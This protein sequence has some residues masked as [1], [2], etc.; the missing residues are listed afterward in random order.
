ME[1]TIPR[2]IFDFLKDYPPFSLLP[3]DALEAVAAEVKVRYFQ[4]GQLV[5]N[6]GDT[7]GAHVFIVREGAIQLYREAE[8]EQ[9]LVEQCDEGDVFGIRPLLAEEDYAL[10]AKAAE[11]SLLYAVPVAG[12]RE[13]LEQNPKI[14]LYLATTFAADVGERYHK[15]FKPSLFHDKQGPEY[16]PSPLIEVQSLTGSKTPV[17][18]LPDTTIQQAAA[19]M[20]EREVGSIIITDADDRPVGIITD[21]DLRK[22]VA[23]GQVGLREK[24]ASI[25][26]SPVIT[27]PPNLQMAEVQIEMV[28]NRINHLCV[29]EDGS[30]DSKVIGVLSEHDLMVMQGNN[31][32]ILIREIRRCTEAEALRSIRERAEVLLEGYIYQEVAISFISAIMT[33]LNDEIIHRAIELSEQEM[34]DEGY[35]APQAG[36]CWMALGSEGRGEQLLRTDQDNALVFEDVPEEE[37]EATKAYYLELAGRVTHKLNQVGFE[38][39]PADMMASNPDWCLSLEQWKLQFSRWIKEPEPKAVMYCT[40]F[41]DYRGVYGKAEL[42][43]ALT[44]HIFEALDGQSVFMSFLA[45]NALE[46]PPPL[47]FFRN[48]VVENSGEHKD[49]FDIKARAM[50]PLADAAR[51]LMLNARLSNINNTFRRFDKLAEME[52]KNKELYEQASDAYEILMRYRALHGLKMKNSGRYFDPSKMTKMERINLRNSFQ[53]I[54]ALQS[55]LNVRFQLAYFR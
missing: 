25:M 27:V 24:V 19:T 54:K 43:E 12:F 7:A 23:T 3:R 42:T 44:E 47:T 50:M 6:Q 13:V 28:R 53:P 30:S 26:S 52:P 14:A 39:C 20:S 51:V 40:I 15:D 10:T 33:E 5:F 22:R 45:K 2:R 17:T 34:A 35:E 16:A 29:T 46:N 32:A 1:N 18:C 21:K 11:E 4:E 9:V 31:P 36:F 41:F 37:Y 48:F 38:Y 49:K 8:E 55:L